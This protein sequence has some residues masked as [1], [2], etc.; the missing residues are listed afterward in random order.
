MTTLGT[1]SRA[2]ARTQAAES[3]LPSPDTTLR[4][5][6]DPERAGPGAAR[7]TQARNSIA[8]AKAHTEDPTAGARCDPGAGPLAGSVAA[9]IAR[10]SSDGSSPVVLPADAQRGVAG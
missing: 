10:S 9:S 8:R 3:L 7:N 6:M 1:R 4:S 2:M 5:L